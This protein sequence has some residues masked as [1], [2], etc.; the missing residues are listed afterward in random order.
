M[1]TPLI[2]IYE[3]REIDTFPNPISDLDE[4]FF[5]LGGYF[6]SQKL[7]L[8]SIDEII[9]IR[10]KEPNFKNHIYEVYKNRMG[11]RWDDLGDESEELVATIQPSYYQTPP[12]KLG[13]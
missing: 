7:A 12:V 3:V 13:A 9:D 2:H 1:N 4:G 10:E 5:S 11:A 8:D 6:A